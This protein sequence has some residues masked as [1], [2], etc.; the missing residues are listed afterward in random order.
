MIKMD[1]LLV[2]FFPLPFLC[3]CFYS[4]IFFHFTYFSLLMTQ[5]RQFG[6]FAARRLPPVPPV[7]PLPSATVPTFSSE[8]APWRQISAFSSSFVWPIAASPRKNEAKCR[9]DGFIYLS[10]RTTG[11]PCL[12]VITNC[13]WKVR[14]V[15]KSDLQPQ[16]YNYN[17]TTIHPK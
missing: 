7:L 1:K 14:P 3:V 2:R 8:P 9:A 15:C 11:R 5:I 16:R 10:E 6:R 13:S 12:V 4:W 17:K